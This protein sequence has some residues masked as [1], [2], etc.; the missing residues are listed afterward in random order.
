M[1]RETKDQVAIKILKKSTMSEEDYIGLYNEVLILQNVDHPN[2]V[3]M[4]EVY[5][6]NTYFCIVLERMKGGE[7]YS[8]VCDKNRLDEKTVH[9]I[10][11]PVFDAVFYCHELG[12]AHRDLKPEN[13][14]LTDE[15]MDK[16]SVKISDFG[17][18]RGISG[19]N[20]AETCCGTPGYVAPE[21]I[22]KQPYD[23]RCDIWSLGVIMFVLLSGTPPFF[24]K[25]NFEL[26]GLI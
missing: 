16:A 3:K 18:A 20:M 7:I 11:V 10:M 15:V 19:G 6:D 5:E 25:D 9:R 22:G 14:L 12:I 26:F 24:H 2:V 8:Q 21:V 1:H 17:L 13:L 23:A 4:I